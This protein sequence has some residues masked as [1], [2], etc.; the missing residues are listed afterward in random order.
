[1]TKLLAALLLLAG[2]APASALAQAP[3]EPASPAPSKS[4]VAAPPV[5]EAPT[6]DPTL[7]LAR[8]DRRLTRCEKDATGIDFL[9]AA[10][11]ALWVILIA[12][13]VIT[14]SRQRR[15]VLEMNE[16]KARLARLHDGRDPS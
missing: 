10:Y 1:M 13:F 4:F 5:D 8:C 11:M 9:A 2:L 3:P 14:R 16:L 15:L 12:F 6:S 7:L